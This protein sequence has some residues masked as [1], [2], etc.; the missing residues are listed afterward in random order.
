MFLAKTGTNRW[1]REIF[2]E[3]KLDF[4]A[5]YVNSAPIMLVH[6]PYPAKGEGR[7]VKGEGRRVK[8]EG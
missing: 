2:W 4:H 1:V 8:G 3:G 5:K 6:V 7:R